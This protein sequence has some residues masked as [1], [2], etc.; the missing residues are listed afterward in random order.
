MNNDEHPCC[1][2]IA[3]NKF[4]GGLF[5]DRVIERAPARLNWN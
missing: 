1:G 5:H 3:F 4:T 2:I